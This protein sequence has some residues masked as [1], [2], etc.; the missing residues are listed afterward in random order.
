MRIGVYLLL[1]LLTACSTRGL[2]NHFAS[3]TEQRL[4]TQSLDKLIKALPAS[5]FQPL[6]EQDVYLQC[7]FIAPT[8]DGTEHSP[9]LDFACQRVKME[10][11]ERF[12]GRLADSPEQA[13]YQVHFFFN[14]I[15]TD[16]D[17]LGITTPE[18]YIPGLGISKIDFI[19][20]EMFHGVSEGYYYIVD[21]RNA[22]TMRG[23]LRKARVRTDRLNLPFISLPLNT[24]D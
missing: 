3:A 12:N 9:L 5:D 2:N 1:L 8:V 21:N 22:E 7:Y 15:G 6:Q 20:L 18:L 16:Q 14:A 10:L 13:A 17:S 19:A 11:L 24:L 23:M 4:V